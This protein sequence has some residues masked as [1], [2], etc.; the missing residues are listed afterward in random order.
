MQF[1]RVLRG[2]LGQA[3]DGVKHRLETAMTGHDCVEH[4]FFRKLFRFRLH[5]EHRVLRAGDDK[6]EIGGFHLFDRRI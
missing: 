5:H 4:G 3:D 6:I 2:A 1:A